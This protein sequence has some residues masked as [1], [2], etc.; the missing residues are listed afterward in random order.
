MVK[1][2]LSSITNPAMA[3]ITAS[4]PADQQQPIKE[5]TGK[6]TSTRIRLKHEPTIE[7]N[8]YGQESKTKRLNLVLK[9]STYRAL[10]QIVKDKANPNSSLNGLIN[11][12]L[13]QYISAN[14]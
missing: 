2:G 1:K 3:F 14:T 13:E 10:E 12:L 9:P 11:E 7:L 6:A 5:K 4:E 8:R